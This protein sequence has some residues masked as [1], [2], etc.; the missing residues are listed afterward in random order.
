MSTYE[1]KSGRSGKSAPEIAKEA[2]ERVRA[3]YAMERQARELSDAK[4][5]ELRNG[6]S[7]PLLAELHDRLL[8]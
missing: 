2:I 5:L 8:D 6:R 7:V 4:R 3:L 1:K